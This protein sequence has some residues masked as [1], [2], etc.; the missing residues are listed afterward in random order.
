MMDD[1]RLD[2]ALRELAADVAFPPTPDLRPIVAERLAGARGGWRPRPAWRLALIG[3]AGATLLLVAA[4]AAFV[5]GLP[6]L[7]IIFVP[8]SAPS[9]AATPGSRLGLGVA[10]TLD[11]ADAEFGGAL[12]LPAAIGPPDEVYLAPDGS[13]V[14]LVYHADGALPGLS[15]SQIGLLVMEVTGTMDG[16]QIE[17][18][19][20]EIG[21]TVTP[22]EVDGARGYW[23]EGEPHVMRYRDPSGATDELVSRLVGDVLVWQRGEVLYRIETGLGY[24]ETLRIAESMAPAP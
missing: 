20:P 7:R 16:D 8:E 23:I 13:L 14:S 6:G 4:A 11:V 22:V 3:A 12:A 21:A 5:F 2:A 24:E 19:V 17:K 15:G 9:A 18:L 10:T 1:A